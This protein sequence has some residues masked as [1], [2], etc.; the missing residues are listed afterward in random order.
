M[1]GGGEGGM[2]GGGEGGMGGGMEVGVTDK[3][4]FNFIAFPIIL[5][6]LN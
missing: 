1:G 6:S 4:F 2:G 3:Y 5:H